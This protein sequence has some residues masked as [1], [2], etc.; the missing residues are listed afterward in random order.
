MVSGFLAWT[1]GLTGWA[2]PSGYCRDAGKLQCL[3]DQ[4][5]DNELMRIR[6]VEYA[7]REQAQNAVNS[8]SNQS[9]MGR[10]VYVREVCRSPRLRMRGFHTESVDR[11]VKP[12]PVS[13]VVPRAAISAVVA[14]VASVV[15]LVAAMAVLPAEVPLVVSSM[16]RTFV[17]LRPRDTNFG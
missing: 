13:S 5:R 16:C 15:D 14:A 11:T 8:L 9:L 3:E 7:T 4:L 12:S 2:W 1:V 6:I 10:L 17:I